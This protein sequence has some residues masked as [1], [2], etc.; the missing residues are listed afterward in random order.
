[1]ENNSLQS[2]TLVAAANQAAIRQLSTGM[3][4]LKEIPWSGENIT[5]A[6]IAMPTDVSM[7]PT[8][9]SATTDAQNRLV[10]NFRDAPLAFSRFAFIRVFG[11][12][13]IPGPLASPRKYRFGL[14]LSSIIRI[15]QRIQTGT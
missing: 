11:R 12:C 7:L 13:R 15:S 1:M 9:Q 3:A 2:P 10:R 8:A 6:R 14:R 4:V 5:K